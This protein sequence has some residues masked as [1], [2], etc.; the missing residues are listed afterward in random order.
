MSLS[1]L[2]NPADQ[3]VV[4]RT[5]SPTSGGFTLSHCFLP[6]DH[7]FALKR[8]S[9]FLH[10]LTFLNQKLQRHGLQGV[11]QQ[12][13]QHRLARRLQPQGG[14]GQEPLRHHRHL[15]RLAF[16]R[17]RRGRR[18]SLPGHLHRHHHAQTS[19]AETSASGGRRRRSRSA[20]EMVA[21]SGQRSTLARS[22]ERRPIF[23]PSTLLYR[24]DLHAYFSLSL[25]VKPRDSRLPWPPL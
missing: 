12:K 5:P 4:R 2:L 6:F 9:I 10:E 11:G 20:V 24:F 22:D 16:R 19:A 8:L 25:S 7:T 3:V 21:G 14:E 17:H 13:V 23:L 18:R 15:P 1:V